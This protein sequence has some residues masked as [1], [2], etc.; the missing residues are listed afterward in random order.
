MSHSAF[1]DAAQPHSAE[2]AIDGEPEASRDFLLGIF[3]ADLGREQGGIATTHA[4]P[5]CEGIAR[6]P[7]GC[8]FDPDHEF[9][10]EPGGRAEG[11]SLEHCV[12][13]HDGQAGTRES[14]LCLARVAAHQPIG[15]PRSHGQRRRACRVHC[16]EPSRS[17]AHLPRVFARQANFDRKFQGPRAHPACGAFEEGV[18]AR[19]LQSGSGERREGGRRAPAARQRG[20]ADEGR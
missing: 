10:V 14:R 3:A 20:S 6:D 7:L 1:I 18:L 15:S 12:V 16:N 11:S 2:N 13:A 5:D 17:V 9:G 8:R 4:R 19:C